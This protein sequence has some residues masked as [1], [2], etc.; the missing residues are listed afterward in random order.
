V[1]AAVI[2][3]SVR[4]TSVV[5]ILAVVLAATCIWLLLTDPVRVAGVMEQGDLLPIFTLL[6]QTLGDL[7]HRLATYL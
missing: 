7:I 2:R 1:S 5:G 4:L 6:G 3:T